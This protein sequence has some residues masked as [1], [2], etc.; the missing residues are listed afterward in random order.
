MGV[1][2]KRGQS[3]ADAL[4]GAE[5][6]GNNDFLDRYR[7]ATRGRS[8]LKNEEQ[9]RRSRSLSQDRR[10]LSKLWPPNTCSSSSDVAGTESSKQTVT[11][12]DAFR[13]K[14]PTNFLTPPNIYSKAGF[15]EEKN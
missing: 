15:A 1:N 6:T 13:S 7:E 8:T 4:G 14:T 5:G 10:R 2:L 11:P 9:I 12:V 3:T